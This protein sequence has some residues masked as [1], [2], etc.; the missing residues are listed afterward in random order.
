MI[1]MMVVFSFEGDEQVTR[2]NLSQNGKDIES[3]QS[4]AHS[5]GM[6]QEAAFQLVTK[7]MNVSWN[8]TLP[9]RFE[10]DREHAY[11]L[12]MYDGDLSRYAGELLET[13]LAAIALGVD[14]IRI[15]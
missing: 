15:S 2:V 3:Y 8:N 10:V 5:C 1:T 12:Y 4:D 7:T 9:F 6:Q 11:R 13:V 14:E